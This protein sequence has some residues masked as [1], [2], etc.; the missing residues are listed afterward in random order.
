MLVTGKTVS[1]MDHPGSGVTLSSGVF[2]YCDLR[3]HHWQLSAASK[4]SSSR[5]NLVP[6]LQPL[7]FTAWH[8]S[9]NHLHRLVNASVSQTYP[10]ACELQQLKIWSPFTL[11]ALAK[12][13]VAFCSGAD[14]QLLVKQPNVSLLGQPCCSSYYHIVLRTQSAHSHMCCNQ[15]VR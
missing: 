12:K 2:R 5:N 11:A 4:L 8:I 3:C 10:P 13:A 7:Q 15:P 6:D 1:S 9:L 14:R